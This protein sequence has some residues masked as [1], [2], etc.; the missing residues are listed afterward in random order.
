MKDHTYIV[1]FKNNSG[2][3]TVYAGHWAAAAIKACA[4]R[5]D[6]GFHYGI[7]RITEVDTSTRTTGEVFIALTMNNTEK[8]KA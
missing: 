8:V 7:E 2:S 4:L 5:I 1:E 6:K 3:E